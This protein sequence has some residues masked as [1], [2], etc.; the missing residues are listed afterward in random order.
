MFFYHSK[1][2]YIRRHKYGKTVEIIE[3]EYVLQKVQSIQ[4]Y[5]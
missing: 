1:L 3:A 2:Q 4:F 5:K